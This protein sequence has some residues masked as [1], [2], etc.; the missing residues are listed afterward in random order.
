MRTT[1]LFII[2]ISLNF[3]SCNTDVIDKVIEKRV[4]IH[5]SSD[6]DEDI[7]EIVDEKDSSED[8]EEVGIE[9]SNPTL[10]DPKP[11]PSENFDGVEISNP[12]L[13]PIPTPSKAQ[14]GPFFANSTINVQEVEI[15]NGRINVSRKIES[16]SFNDQIIDNL[17]SFILPEGIQTRH[18]EIGV[19]GNYFNEISGEPSDGPISL[20]SF[21]SL[22][23]GEENNI[24]ILTTL[25]HPRIRYLMSQYYLS[26]DNAQRQAQQELLAVFSAGDQIG[27]FDELTIDRNSNGSAFLLAISTV[28]QGQ[29]NSQELNEF[30][31]LIRSSF[32]SRG[33]ID[34]ED[35]LNQLC[36][37]TQHLNPLRIR[38]NLINYYHSQNFEEY[39]IPPFEDYLDN[40]CDGII[41]KNDP[42]TFISF[43]RSIPE[44]L[45]NFENFMMD[46]FQHKLWLVNQD[47]LFFSEDFQNWIP[48]ENSL[49]LSAS[50]S[51]LKVW[52]NKL[53]IFGGESC[54]HP[55]FDRPEIEICLP[56]MGVYTIDENEILEKIALRGFGD[57][58]QIGSQEPNENIIP[59]NL[60]F[61]N[62]HSNNR[63]LDNQYPNFIY[64]IQSLSLL[65]GE[66][67]AYSHYYLPIYP[68]NYYP[69]FPLDQVSSL[70]NS[71]KTRNGIEWNDGN[72]HPQ[73][74]Y[75]AN[76]CD[77]TDFQG[78]VFRL[79]SVSTSPFDCYLY[80]SY[81]INE[82]R[83]TQPQQIFEDRPISRA[84]LIKY[85][86]NLI[87]S[88]SSRMNHFNIQYTSDGISWNKLNLI[89]EY[90]S[91]RKTQPHLIFKNFM[92]FINSNNML[93]IGHYQFYQDYIEFLSRSDEL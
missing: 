17:G 28:I 65:N 35:I 79:S 56:T 93:I 34:N 78:G 47:G 22:N 40:D 84:K 57:T 27:N 10:P 44:Q 90:A 53:Y 37:Q 32:S 58:Y 4:P 80:K 46:S 74:A 55:Y 91:F 77:I 82:I 73:N 68:Y 86:S 29:L 92:H 71:L 59:P 31:E 33:F 66:L 26:F 50:K 42:E 41:N 23:T 69:P 25:I 49:D 14:K 36:E 63:V 13:P 75:S 19:T 72:L 39:V 45:S 5:V 70:Y 52:D 48:Y 60:D 12:E 83:T 9:I 8:P 67:H 38:N 85:N 6:N 24:N 54:S 64:P 87:I 81:N 20:S 62:I 21:S 15:I 1:I 11:K 61:I 18:V 89:S 88:H 3:I 51:L 30:I 7:D 43:S 2:L 76:I 16:N